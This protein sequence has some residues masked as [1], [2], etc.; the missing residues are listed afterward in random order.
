V[1]PEKEAGPLPG[2]GFPHQQR[3][4][5]GPHHPFCGLERLTNGPQLVPRF[6]HPAFSPKPP[7]PRRCDL[8]FGKYVHHDP[9]AEGWASENQESSL[10]AVGRQPGAGHVVLDQ[11]SHKAMWE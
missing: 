10:G 2:P 5:W 1:V 9:K 8:C 4:T 7:C 3:A 6:A 11:C